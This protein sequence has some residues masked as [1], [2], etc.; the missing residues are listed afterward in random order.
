MKELIK[1]QKIG[2]L[3][4]NVARALDIGEI[5]IYQSEGLYKHV[6]KRHP[7]CVKYLHLIPR[8]VADPD[9][10]GINPRETGHS[11]ELVKVINENVQIGIKLDVHHNYYFVATLHTIT[12]AKLT[13]RIASGRLVKI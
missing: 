2:K 8:I 6:S 13:R 7:E 4:K 12:D 3:N 10:F 9:F 5:K 11:F 1:L